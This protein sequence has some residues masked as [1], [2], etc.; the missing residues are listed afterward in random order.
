MQKKRKNLLQIFG[1][2][3]VKKF[4]LTVYLLMIGSPVLAQLY[5]NKTW[6]ASKPGAI[7]TYKALGVGNSYYPYKT[8]NGNGSDTDDNVAKLDNNIYNDIQLYDMGEGLILSVD[9][10][11]YCPVPQQNVKIVVA[12]LMI[13]IPNPYTNTLD[14]YRIDDYVWYSGFS[15]EFAAPRQYSSNGIVLQDSCSYSTTQIF[16]VTDWFKYAWL[17]PDKNSP[18][19]MNLALTSHDN[20]AMTFSGWK[21]LNWSLTVI[22]QDVKPSDFNFDQTV[23]S[24][25]FNISDNNWTGTHPPY[26][27]I[28]W[29]QGDQ[30]GDGFIDNLDLMEIMGNFD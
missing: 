23:N 11:G 15:Q 2:I 29:E 9:L 12:Y 19:Y 13:D 27:S 3:E 6:Q 4:I 10:F 17:Q 30:T 25:D 24:L 21:N 16:E 28:L 7:G 18:W 22:Y 14:L 8:T 1:E 26:G 5:T 20:E